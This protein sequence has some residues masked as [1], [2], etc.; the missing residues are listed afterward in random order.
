MENNLYYALTKYWFSRVI[1][2]IYYSERI[3]FSNVGLYGTFSDLAGIFATLEGS[4]AEGGVEDRLREVRDAAIL[5][6]YWYR[7]FLQDAGTTPAE[8][9]LAPP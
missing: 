6:P 5:L 2:H 8:L 4:S 3:L 1:Y 9:Q 7:H